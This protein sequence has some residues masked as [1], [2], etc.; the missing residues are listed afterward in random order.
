MYEFQVDNRQAQVAVFV[1]GTY[2]TI[3]IDMYMK[4]YCQIYVL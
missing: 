4:R 2:V 3:L 1:I